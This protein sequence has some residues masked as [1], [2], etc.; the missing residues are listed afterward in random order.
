MR[1]S[2]NGETKDIQAATVAELVTV[3]ELP[4]ERVAIEHN[5]MIVRRADRVGVVLADGDRIEIVTLVG[6]G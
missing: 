6:G 2:I 1:L 3:L 5:G 4:S